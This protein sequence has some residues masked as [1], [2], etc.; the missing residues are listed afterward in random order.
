MNQPPPV[1]AA[2]NYR[3]WHGGLIVFGILLIL[4]GAVC[5]LFTLVA[6]LTPPPTPG[7]PKPVGGRVMLPVFL[8]Y[9]GLAV[10]NVWLGIGSIRARRW[11]RA[12]TLLAAW[13]WLLMGVC[14]LGLMVFVLPQTLGTTA[15][16]EAV[17]PA[18]AMVGVIVAVVMISIFFVLVPLGFILFYQ[19]RNTKLTCEARDPVER[20][21]DACPLP[22]L[23]LALLLALSGATMLL[24]I[25][26]YNAVVPCFGWLLS[27]PSGAVLLLMLA[28]AAAWFARAVYRLEVRG[29]WGA[30]G[31]FTLMAVSGVLTD[32]EDMYRLAGYGPEILA[33]LEKQGNVWQQF[34]QLMPLVGMVPAMA[35]MLFVKRYFTKPT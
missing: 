35:Y 27:G 15:G 13:A 25:V 17:P 19:H 34:N 24:M 28:G 1:P 7:G 14:M 2:A 16:Q 11:A 20:W 5:A 10:G 6:G 3:D 18:A 29:W 22:V 32:T 30:L 8:I 26:A 12:L 9:G 23:A 31:L 4:A 21:T 33:A